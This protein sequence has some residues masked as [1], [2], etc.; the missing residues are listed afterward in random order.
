MLGRR[1]FSTNRI[2]RSNIG[3]SPILLPETA[4]LK[5]IPCVLDEVS[6]MRME[7]DK[8]RNGKPRIYLTQQAEITG[9]KGKVLM[10]VADFI[11]VGQDGAK[12]TIEVEEPEKRHQRSMWGTTRTLLSNNIIGVT[13]GHL[14]IVK[15]V[16]TGFRAQLEKTGDGKQQ[17]SL[18]VG[19]CDAK[20]VPVPD[21]LT[22]TVPVPHRVVIEGCDKQQVKL[23]AAE[24]RKFRKPEPYKGKGIFIDNETIKLKQKKIK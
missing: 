22:V 12:I 23:L 19:Y 21:D 9:P 8:K 2:V 3:S 18:R 4:Q 6:Q 14:C 20:Q 15:L 1:L 13:E 17:L 10:D 11:K 5:L 7:L 24:I 16:G